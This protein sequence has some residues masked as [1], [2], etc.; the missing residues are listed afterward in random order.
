MELI[1][2][3]A[4]KF[5]SE[6]TEIHS[7]IKSLISEAETSIK[8]ATAWFTDQELFDILKQKASQG[9]SVEVVISNKKENDR[10]NFEELRL[11][12]G[13][14]LI[15]DVSS[16]GMMHQKYCIVDNVT[17]IQGS[18]NW[19]INAKKNNKEGVI[20]TSHKETVAQMVADFQS[21]NK[22]ISKGVNIF[23]ELYSNKINNNTEMEELTNEKTND[24][25]LEALLNHIIE[26]EFNDVDLEEI[27]NNGRAAC[28]VSLGNVETM[29]VHLDSLKCQFRTDASLSEEKKV[30]ILSRIEQLTKS[31]LNQVD[32]SITQR[33]ESLEITLQNDRKAITDLIE[34]RKRSLLELDSNIKK[35]ELNKIESKKNQIEKFKDQLIDL[36]ANM[37][38]KRIALYDLIPKIIIGT[39]LAGIVYLF[40]S[41][42]MYIM[43][44]TKADVQEVLFNG[45]IPEM[46]AF[47]DAHAIM[48]AID[49]GGM[50]VVFVCL[51]PAFIYFF[52]FIKRFTKSW[53]KWQQIVITIGSVVFIDGV[54]AYIV[55]N[56]IHHSKYLIGEVQVATISITEAIVDINFL[57]VLICGIISLLALKAV[58]TSIWES[59][60][61]RN[62]D[63]VAIQLKVESEKLNGRINQ[64][65]EIIQEGKSEIIEF[66]K[67]IQIQNTEL[68]QFQNNLISAQN[69]HQKSIDDLAAEKEDKSKYITELSDIYNV[70]VEK[71]NLPFATHYLTHRLNSFVEG[72]NEFLYQYYAKDVADSKV[73]EAIQLCNSWSNNT[74]SIKKVA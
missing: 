67:E 18:Y 4:Q 58:I 43:L 34:G 62:E 26:S 5:I 52:A 64:C 17:A 46:P 19:T 9:V 41:S 40:Y 47:F 69:E 39:G 61:K 65:E 44:Y 8:V 51:I 25:N 28:E 30:K 38:T 70:R 16:Y 68:S 53:E 37:K 59:F 14:V 55:A 56:T 54:I 74:Q 35:V 22:T 49:K 36:K 60:D 50:A 42:A 72:W 31:R 63:E 2:N 27:K 32:Q 20:I 23:K 13:K 33:I 66:E 29:L 10:L 73:N 57:S 3:K 45:G 6:N 15:K 11:L 71:E 1:K 21:L 24:T 48:K 7:T 12:G